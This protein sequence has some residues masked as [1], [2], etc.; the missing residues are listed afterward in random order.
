VAITSYLTAAT[1][2][3]LFPRTHT[4][5]YN[6]FVFFFHFFCT[7]PLQGCCFSCFNL[8]L[9]FSHTLAHCW[10][11]FTFDFSQWFFASI[12][13]ATILTEIPRYLRAFIYLFGLFYLIIFYLIICCCCFVGSFRQFSQMPAFFCYEFFVSDSTFLRFAFFLLI[14]LCANLFAFCWNSFCCCC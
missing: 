9:K 2:C 10:T 11:F 6:C 4:F 7:I 5:S 12:H 3:D 14:V 8:S 13:F 1:L